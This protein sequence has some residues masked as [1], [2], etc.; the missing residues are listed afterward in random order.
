MLEFYVL[1]SFFLDKL[2]SS[3]KASI[4]CF[5]FPISAQEICS[6][7]LSISEICREGMAKLQVV[8]C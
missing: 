7:I 3:L 4:E 6:F 1:K 2:E 8:K 5:A